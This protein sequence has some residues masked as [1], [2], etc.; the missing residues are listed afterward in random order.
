MGAARGSVHIG[1]L[2]FTAEQAANPRYTD[3]DPS[4]FLE[5][6]RFHS[7]REWAMWSA[8]RVSLLSSKGWAI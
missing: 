4:G 8:R 1:G 3:E 5:C 6:G 2:D 7:N